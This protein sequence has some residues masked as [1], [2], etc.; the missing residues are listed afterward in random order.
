LTCEQNSCTPVP[1]MPRKSRA[2]AKKVQVGDHL[3][4]YGRNLDEMQDSNDLFEKK[5]FEALRLK[6]EEEGYLFIRG[7]V[8]RDTIISA[9]KAMLKQAAKEGSIVDDDEVS[10]DQA[11]MTKKGSVWADGYCVDGI[12]GSE[13][14]ERPNIEVDA[15]E[16]I[17]PSATCQ[18]VYNGKA[19]QSFW[20]SLFGQ[21]SIRPL[22]KQTFLRLMGSSGTV[23]HADYYYFKRDTHIF[24]G[25]DGLNAQ[26]A[27]RQ[28]LTKH[29]LWKKDLYELESNEIKKSERNK[30][31]KESD[32]MK[33]EDN[34]SSLKC[35]ICG[36]WYSE[37]DL[38]D[39]RRERLAKAN[40]KKMDFGME[41]QWHCPQCAL[42]PLSIYTTWISLTDDIGPKESVLAVIPHSHKLKQWDTPRPNS[43]LPG[44]F[45]WKLKWVIP[46]KVNFGD[47]II[48]NIKT[49]HAS[50]KNNSSPRRYRCSFDTRLQLVPPEQDAIAEKIANLELDD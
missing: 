24:S 37:E 14:N 1:T 22:V 19:I 9:R 26:I 38:D 40:K 7:V 30:G 31:K 50:S 23:Q 48:F 5:D 21:S 15:W 41:G 29:D 47:V 10:M 18:N 17:G 43:Q 11:M 33:Q 45:N 49:I 13:T 27:A 42:S 32:D 6:L 34:E 28:Y 46:S 36:E 3:L 8:P 16:E 44:D 20:K 4:T 25:E 12:T 35:G 39:R 2:K